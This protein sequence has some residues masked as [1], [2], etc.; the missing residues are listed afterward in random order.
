MNAFSDFKPVKRFHNKSYIM[1]FWSICDSTSSR[2]KNK[3][4][5]IKLIGRKVEK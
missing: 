4:K 1:K 3:L 5:T 2:I